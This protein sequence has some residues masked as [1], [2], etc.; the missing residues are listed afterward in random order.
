[1]PVPSARPTPWLVPFIRAVINYWPCKLPA[2]Y[3]A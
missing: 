2:G 3:G 1:M